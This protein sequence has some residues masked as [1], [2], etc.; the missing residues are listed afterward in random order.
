MRASTPGTR[1]RW[2]RACRPS[3]QSS[4]GS[5]KPVLL[6]VDFDSGHGTGSSAQM[7]DETTDLFAFLLWQTGSPDFALP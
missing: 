6:R 3:A 2:P 1:A 5:G 4:G 7:V